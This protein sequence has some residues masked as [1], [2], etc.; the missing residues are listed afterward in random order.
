MCRPPAGDAARTR[1]GARGSRPTV[2][3]RSVTS[4]SVG[5]R[6]HVSPASWLRKTPPQVK[7]LA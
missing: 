3:T 7:S 5:R 6:S 2:Q 4:P 1:S